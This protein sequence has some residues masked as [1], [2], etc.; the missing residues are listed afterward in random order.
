[1]S[2]YPSIEHLKESLMYKEGALFWKSRPLHHFETSRAM[3]VFNSRF[4]GKVAG[5]FLGPKNLYRIVWVSIQGRKHQILEHVAVWA[6]H[7]DRYPLS[8]IDHEDGNGLN[9]YTNNLSEKT[10]NQNMQ[11]KALYKNNKSGRVGVGWYTRGGKWVAKGTYNG[12]KYHLGYY[13]DLSLAIKAR[14]VWE[15]GKDFTERHGK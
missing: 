9:N 3:N 13:E 1:M 7:N 12:V 6:L 14:E 11:N 10:R 5:T 15:V 2:L 4:P 8:D